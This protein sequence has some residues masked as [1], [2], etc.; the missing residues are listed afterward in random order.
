MNAYQNFLDFFSMHNKERLDGLSESYF[1][2]MTPAERGTEE[3]V[4]GLFRADPV[5]AVEVMERRLDEGTLS[6][7]A[8]IAAA[9]NLR[10]NG[11][12]TDFLP[13]FIRYMSSPDRHLR[14]KAAYFVPAEFSYELK[15]A[16]QAMIRTE[17][18]QL[19]RIHAV[20]TLLACYGVSEESVGD[21]MYCCLYLGLHSED[22]S[23]KERAFKR[24]DA[25]YE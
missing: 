22:P 21:D 5:H 19:P 14:R 15:A 1:T 10:R 6:G 17:N 16:L 11:S 20:D 7:E 25:L 13:I 4:H 2:A 23:A 8:Q 18:E 9:W 3:S 12:D 24:L